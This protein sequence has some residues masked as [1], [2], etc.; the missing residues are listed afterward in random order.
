[1]LGRI[2]AFDRWSAATRCAGPCSWPVMPN[3]AAEQ[4]QVDV[5]EAD[6]AT[7]HIPPT[8]GRARRLHVD[9]R[10]VVQCPDD[11]GEAWHAMTVEVDGRREWARQI[12]TSNPGQ[13]D[14]LD[15]H[16]RVEVAVGC[17]LR[18]RALTRVHRAMRRRLR[19][20]AVEA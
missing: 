17:G 15:Y 8:L 2:E 19:I 10:F 18:V 14:S 9:V 11:G 1:L 12:A 6:V 4:W 5:G 13:S 16:F 3:S 7:L 20:E